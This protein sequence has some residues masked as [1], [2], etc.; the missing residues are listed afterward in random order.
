MST[1]R[2]TDQ[3]YGIENSKFTPHIGS[4]LI[5]DV[6]AKSIGEEKVS[7]M[8]LEVGYPYYG[9]HLDSESYLL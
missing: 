8:F 4:H 5:F 9:M 1:N 7:T 2:H 3:D 6:V